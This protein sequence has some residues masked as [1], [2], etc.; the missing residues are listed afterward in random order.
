MLTIIE[1]ELVE[2]I[3]LLAC[4][5]I[6][7]YEYMLQKIVLFFINTEYSQ[8]L[9]TAQE[10]TTDWIV[11]RYIVLQFIQNKYKIVIIKSV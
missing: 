9:E 10:R 8:S 5:Y 6:H 7:F 2:H 1:T 4:M 3:L 11:I